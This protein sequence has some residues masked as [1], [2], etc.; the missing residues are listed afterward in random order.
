MSRRLSLAA[1]ATAAVTLPFNAGVTAAHAA[2]VT[3][4][5]PSPITVR[6]AIVSNGQMLDMEHWTPLVFEKEHPNI[7]VLFDTL[8]EDNE[9][10]LIEK[11]I[12]THAGLFDGIMISNY[13]TP[14]FA[15][16][17]WLTDLSPDAKATPGYDASDFLPP[18]AESLSYDGQLYGVPFY[19]ESSFLIYRKDL[20]AKAGLTMPLHPTWGQVASFAAKLTNRSAG[21][22]GICLRGAPGWGMNLAPLDTVV[23]TF[24]GVWFNMKW[25][26]QLTSP[27]FESAVTF[28]V[29]LL[30]KYGE[31]SAAN[32]TFDDILNE[33]NAGKCAMWY[34][35]T[36]LAD[37]LT[38][39]MLAKS[40]FVWAPV[41]KTK[42]SGWLYTWS[43]SIPSDISEAEK[44]ATWEF[45]SWAT[46]KQY[47]NFIAQKEGWIKVPPGSR[48]SVYENPAFKRAVPFGAI[49]LQSIDAAN[50]VHPST[51]PQPY[52]GVQFVGIPEFES[53]GDA[54]SRQISGAIAGTETVQQA[55]AT[56]QSLALAATSSYR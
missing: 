35:A 56:S 55:L 1:L 20:F 31:P 43:L 30:R 37:L 47:D 5:A 38:P 9:R 18:I 22:A 7:H 12:T 54:V 15:K 45:I 44:A 48:T 36:S 41:D 24:G 27:P 14:W 29:N 10:P 11:D 26:P 25:Q 52:M 28:Y 16:N 17:G 2:V 46:S 40:G 53:L 50:P 8:G 4:S 39:A 42:Y 51:Q 21:I 23:N 32:A 49:T 34:D 13:E 19:G 33:Y 3:S 6:M